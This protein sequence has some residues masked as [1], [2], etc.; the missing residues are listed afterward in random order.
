MGCF[1]FNFPYSRC[2]FYLHDKTEQIASALEKI[3]ERGKKIYLD[4]LNKIFAKQYN[5]TKKEGAV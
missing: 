1:E 5:A 3:N 4:K 2:S